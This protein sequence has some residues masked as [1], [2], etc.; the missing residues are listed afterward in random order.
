MSF[1]GGAFGMVSAQ[2]ILIRHEVDPYSTRS[3]SLHVRSK[4]AGIRKHVSDSDCVVKITVRWTAA[5]GGMLLSCW[6]A[7]HKLI[8]V[9]LMPTY[10]SLSLSLSLSLSS[11]SSSSLCVLGLMYLYF[12]Y[13]CNSRICRIHFICVYFVRSGFRTKVKCV[14][15]VQIES[16]V[17]QCTRSM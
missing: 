17:E 13:H 9:F 3:R 1:C 8:L 15:K 16:A 12:V 14:L 11:S 10:F 6:I 7:D 4:C 5:P 2:S